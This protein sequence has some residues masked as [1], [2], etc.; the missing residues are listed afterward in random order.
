MVNGT[1]ALNGSK[2]ER[3]IHYRNRAEVVRKIVEDFS[4]ERLRKTLLDVAARYDTRADE[5]QRELNSA[6]QI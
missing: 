2:L 3:L 4:E 1:T 5:I 6:T